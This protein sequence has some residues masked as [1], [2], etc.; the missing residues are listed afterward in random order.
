MGIFWFAFQIND[1]TVDIR[2]LVF[3][4]VFMSLWATIMLEFWKRRESEL[5]AIWGQEFF[6]ETE[7]VRP[8]FVE[9]IYVIV[10]Y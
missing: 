6:N 10:K 9:G 1:K 7:G 8:D 2:G 3:M 5:R 4:A